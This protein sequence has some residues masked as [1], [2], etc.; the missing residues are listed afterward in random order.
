VAISSVV[1]A[2][3]LMRNSTTWA[4]SPLARSLSYSIV[5]ASA[6]TLLHR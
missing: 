3:N 1:N 4:L 6:S 2:A 5:N